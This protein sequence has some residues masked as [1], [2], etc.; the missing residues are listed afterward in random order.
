MNSGP[1]LAFHIHIDISRQLIGITHARTIANCFVTDDRDQ[2]RRHIKKSRLDASEMNDFSS[3]GTSNAFGYV[4]SVV[5][6]PQPS[7]RPLSSMYPTIV[8]FEN[9][10]FYF[11]ELLVDRELLP[12]QFKISGTY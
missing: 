3:P 12:Q 1:R 10:T 6:Y 2:G 11:A 4:A 8:E 7:K 5:N 9:G